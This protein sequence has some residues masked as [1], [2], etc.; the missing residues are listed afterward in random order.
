MVY[1]IDDIKMIP[2]EMSTDA[3]DVPDTDEI[4]IL[5]DGERVE[6]DV[7]PV[8]VDDRTLVPFRAIFEALGATVEWEAETRTA[9]GVRGDIAVAIQ[10]DNPVMKLNDADLTLDVPAQ[11]IDDRTMVPVR[12]I[13]ESFQAEVEW[14]PET[15]T[16]IVT[17]K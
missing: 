16:V 4:Q 9:K 1:Y 14:V 11:I 6:A 3:P 10:I 13:S 12:A 7:P 8:I 17:T 5:V 2:G 15:R